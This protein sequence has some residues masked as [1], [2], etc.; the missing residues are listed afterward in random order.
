MLS[1][2]TLCSLAAAS[3]ITF[4]CMTSESA[5]ADTLSE[6]I[7]WEQTIKG[8]TKTVCQSPSSLKTVCAL[9]DPHNRSEVCK[10]ATSS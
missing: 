1:K 7:C 9:S 8:K 10:K 6:L 4:A 2:I 3:G 5:Q